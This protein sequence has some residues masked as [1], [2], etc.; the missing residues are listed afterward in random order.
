MASMIEPRVDAVAPLPG[1]P[2][3]LLH[4]RPADKLGF[5]VDLQPLLGPAAAAT[6]IEWIS[7]ASDTLTLSAARTRAGRF[8]VFE[9]AGGLVEAP[10]P[11]QDHP[12]RAVVRTTAGTVEVA[13]DI[14][15]HAR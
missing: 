2:P 6:G 9:A 4:K 3:V 12:V 8:L 11:H 1:K 15:V 7:C 14:R 10:R 13:I 5:T